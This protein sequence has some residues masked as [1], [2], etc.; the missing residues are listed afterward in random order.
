M[1]EYTA[2]VNQ[3]WD[4]QVPYEFQIVHRYPD[5]EI[6]IFDVHTLMTEIYYNPST[7]LNGTAPANSTGFYY[8]CD[9]SGKNCYDYEAG[10]L[11]SFMWYDELH[12]SNR[13]DQIIANEFIQ[14]VEGNSKYA[15][16]W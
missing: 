15:T 7:Y 4:F 3:I 2:T 10:S 9:D 8:H 6:A 5:A 13:T 11:D 14:V 1:L 16:Y 12:K